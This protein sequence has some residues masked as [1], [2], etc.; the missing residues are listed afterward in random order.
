MNNKEKILK[1]KKVLGICKAVTS[2]LGFTSSEFQKKECGAKHFPSL[3]KERFKK[4]NKF[5]KG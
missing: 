4:L 2:G 3:V 1:K 5:Q